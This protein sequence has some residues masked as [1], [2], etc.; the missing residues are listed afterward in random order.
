LDMTGRTIGVFDSGVGGISVLRELLRCLPNERFIYY[1]DSANAPYGVKSLSEVK[2]LSLEIANYLILERGV[3]A[4]VV[5][6][7]TATSAAINVLRQEFSIPIIGMEP[8]LKPAVAMAGGGQVLVMATP[9]TIR[10]DKFQGLL[11]R[12]GGR[13]KVISLPC[14][15]L[16]E[17]IEKGE[18]TGDRLRSL[19]AALL[20]PLDLSKIKVVVLGCT[21]YVFIKTEIASFFPETANVIDGN[22]GTAKQVRRVLE[23]QG[24]LSPAE[25]D[26]RQERVEWLTSGSQR[27]IS[28][29]IRHL[30]LIL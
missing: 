13:A 6:C 5:A 26:P 7:N 16:V 4:L 2:R 29:M 3:K 30:G 23:E 19:L 1:A 27:E 17:L 28:L 10:E 22:L 14:P 15:G 11:S 24:L 12:Y 8:A 20:S 18:V 25:L 9:M 21:H